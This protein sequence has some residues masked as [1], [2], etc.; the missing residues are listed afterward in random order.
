MSLRMQARGPESYIILG[1][2]FYLRKWFMFLEYPGQTG[3]VSETMRQVD[4]LLNSFR[5]M[6][7]ILNSL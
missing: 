1:M 3:Q 6:E 5:N 4:T 2:W 7:K